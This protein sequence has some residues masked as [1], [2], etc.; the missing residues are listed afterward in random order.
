MKPARPPSS[1]DLSRYRRAS[2]GRLLPVLVA[3]H[4]PTTTGSGGRLASAP[5]GLHAP[6]APTPAPLLE[7]P[8]ETA[9]SPPRGTHF[10]T[11]CKTLDPL[12]VGVY[13]GRR[14]RCGALPARW[15]RRRRP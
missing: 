6:P 2:R 10:A 1:E 7:N 13:T 15:S 14:A 4:L 12:Y 8:A 11:A 5:S 3:V 9:F